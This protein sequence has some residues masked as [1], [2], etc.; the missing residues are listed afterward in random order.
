MDWLAEER[1]LERTR[2]DLEVRPIKGNDI[3]SARNAS[4]GF[5]EA[6]RRAGK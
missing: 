5:T 6:A 3:Y 4:T 1:V 2:A